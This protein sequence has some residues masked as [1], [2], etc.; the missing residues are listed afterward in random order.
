MS[1]T[2]AKCECP[3][4]LFRAWLIIWST[5]FVCATNER[6]ERLRK[7]ERERE[8][9]VRSRD[10][11]I[12]ARTKSCAGVCKRGNAHLQI[13]RYLA[14]RSFAALFFYGNTP[15]TSEYISL[16][17]MERNAGNNNDKRAMLLYL[18]LF[19]SFGE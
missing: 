2:K 14:S 3:R 10:K 15:L 18:R 12:F 5:R 8:N 7:R 19:I 13:I 11:Q 6:R 4:A 9:R 16:K 1:H 17:P